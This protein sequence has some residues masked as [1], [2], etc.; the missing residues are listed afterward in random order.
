MGHRGLA[1]GNKIL[2]ILVATLLCATAYA[3]SNDRWN[4]VTGIVVQTPVRVRT[5]D[6][7][8]YKGRLAAVTVDSIRV[9]VTAQ[10]TTIARKDVRRV[11]VRSGMRRVRNMLIGGGIGL[12]AGIVA[13]FG[14]CPSCVG[15]TSAE[16]F[17]NRLGLG[18][19][20]GAGIGGGL[21]A[22]GPPYKTI[23]KGTRPKP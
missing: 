23:Y 6:G 8:E 21:G 12:A 17:Q 20:A 15:E 16:S 22:I 9:A 2:F 7:A 18:G 14:T 1:I 10:E 5:F 11:Q 19:L 13:A 3:Q 4:R